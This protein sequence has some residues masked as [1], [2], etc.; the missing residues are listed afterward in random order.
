MYCSHD[1]FVTN[2]RPQRSRNQVW[3]RRRCTACQ[4]VFTTVEALDLSKAVTVHGLPFSRDK[5]YISIYEACKH[6]QAAAQDAAGLTATI[7]NR[8]LPAIIHGQ[9][10][11]PTIVAVAGDVLRRFDAAAAVHY[12]AYHKQSLNS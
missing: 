12:Q 8:L 6:R 10:E 7:I 9:L 2:S 5:L 4:A 3:R 11:A 1:L